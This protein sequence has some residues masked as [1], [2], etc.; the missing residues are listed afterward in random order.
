[1]IV[2]FRKWGSEKTLQ[3]NAVN[4]LLELYV[5]FHREAEEDES[6]DQ[7][8][9]DAFRDLE[10]RE[11]EAVALWEQ[12]KTISHAEFD[13]I[14]EILGVEFDLVYGESFLND[15]MDPLIERLTRDGL[16]SMSQGALVVEL[17]DP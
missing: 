1:M 11:P 9:R 12:F 6:L 8:A 17:N 7:A 10:K 2:A 5:R 4:N 15:K 14:Y 16:T 3:G 13:R